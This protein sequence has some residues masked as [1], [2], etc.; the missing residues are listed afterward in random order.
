MNS[1]TESE[2]EIF[3]LDELKQLGFSYLPGPSIAP[4]VEA[5]Q[6]FMVAEPATPYGEPEKRESYGDVVLKHT[7][8][9]AIKRLNPAL[10][11]ASTSRKQ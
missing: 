11:A 5:I 7:L 2:I 8:E 4:D 10:L 1:F 6:G 9:Q 3:S